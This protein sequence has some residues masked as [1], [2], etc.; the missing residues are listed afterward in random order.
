[1]SSICCLLSDQA[2]STLETQQFAPSQPAVTNREI[3]A[4][5]QGMDI[6]LS[7]PTRDILS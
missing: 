7:Y 2:E 4:G 6:G 5:M 3:E 1:M